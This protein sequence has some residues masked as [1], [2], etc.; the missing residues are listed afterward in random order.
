MTELV[1]TP[2]GGGVY[3]LTEAAGGDVVATFYTEGDGWWRGRA[4]SGAV[5]RFF[6]GD[7]PDA[8]LVAA[9]RLRGM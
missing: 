9:G 3:F 1:V 7:V 6:V 4:P 5:K 2:A 8:H